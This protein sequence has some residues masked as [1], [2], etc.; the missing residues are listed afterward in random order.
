MLRAAHIS[1]DRIHALTR[2]WLIRHGEPS[3][4]FRN[5]CYGSLDI[6]LSDRGRAQMEEVGCFLKDEPI[7]AI[8]SSPKSRAIESARLVARPNSSI[9]ICDELREMDFGDFEGL[10]FDDIAARCPDL[11]R[12]WM[13]SPTRIRFPNGDCFGDMRDRVLAAFDQ[14]QREW[15]DRTIAIVSHA[16]VNRV[17][18][19]WALHVPDDHLFCIAQ[20]YASTSLLGFVEGVPSV[21]LWNYRPGQHPGRST[22]SPVDT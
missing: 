14:I 9:R 18:L 11:Y 22:A 8:Y 4:E 15:K 17:L 6:A 12:Q 10:S 2:V 5:R 13:Q 16:G 1:L 21:Q 3:E 20:D 19:A 7:A